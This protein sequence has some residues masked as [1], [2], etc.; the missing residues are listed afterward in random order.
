MRPAHHRLREGVAAAGR[1]RRQA[2]DGAEMAPSRQ[3]RG[4]A[5][6]LLDRGLSRAGGSGHAVTLETNRQS[7]V[8]IYRRLWFEVEAT[9]L[10]DS[11]PQWSMVREPLADS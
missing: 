11:L 9:C 2:T 10:T 5:R 3:G 7:N 6:R 8:D 4:L 1:R